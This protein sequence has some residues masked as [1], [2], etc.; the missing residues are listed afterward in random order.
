MAR[1]ATVDLDPVDGGILATLDARR[2]EYGAVLAHEFGLDPSAVRRRC[3]RL[4]D[5]GFVERVTAESLYRLTAV[6][7]RYLARRTTTP[8][9]GPSD[10]S[11][12][13]GD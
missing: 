5:R 12:P 2:F 11:V 13:S 7:R 9:P 8:R 3:R 10:S 6:G 4:A 1:T